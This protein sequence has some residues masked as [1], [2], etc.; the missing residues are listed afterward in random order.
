MVA[1]HLTI[2]QFFSRLSSLF[3]TCRTSTHGTICLTQ[4]RLSHP[5][6]SSSTSSPTANAAPF[7]DLSP[8]SPLPILVRA[9]NGK[10]KERRDRKIKLSTVVQPDELEGFYTRYAELIKAGT[11]M[12]KKRDRSGR[13]KVAKAKKKQKGE[14]EKK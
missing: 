12:L 8:D 9:S 7:P 6:P 5:S 13:K 1:Q 4:K 3:D 2:D 10:S 14:G 11:P